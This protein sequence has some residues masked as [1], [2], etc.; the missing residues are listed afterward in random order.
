MNGG[1]GL[2]EDSSRGEWFCVRAGIVDDDLEFHRC[3]SQTP[4]PFDVMLLLRVRM[5]KLVKPGLVIE[6]NE[7]TQ[8][9]RCSHTTRSNR[10]SSYAVTRSILCMASRVRTSRILAELRQ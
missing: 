8:E 7:S 3:P 6:A 2:R 5:A 9:Y 1:R 10:P 4:V